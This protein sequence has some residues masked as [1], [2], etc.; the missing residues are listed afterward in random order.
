MDKRAVES[1]I[2][3]WSNEQIA[4]LIVSASRLL[5]LRLESREASPESEWSAVTS[6]TTGGKVVLLQAQQLDQASQLLPLVDQAKER[7]DW[8]KGSKGLLR[9]TS[10]AYTVNNLAHETN[11]ITRITGAITTGGC[12]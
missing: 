7:K 3:S 11:G 10:G 12:E 5:Q 4:A 2:E 8:E 1:A 9:A 6:V